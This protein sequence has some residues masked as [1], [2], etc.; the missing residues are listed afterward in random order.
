M[1]FSRGSLRTGVAAGERMIDFCPWGRDPLEVEPSLKPWIRTWAGENTIFLSP[2]DWFLRGHDLDGGAYNEK[3]YWIPRITSGTYVWSPPAA[4]AMVCLEELR[5]AR[6]KRKNSR[7]IVIIQRLMTPRW[8][9]QL[10]KAADYIFTISPC[11]SFWSTNNFEPLYVALIFPY[12][13]YRP[14]QLKQTPKFFQVGGRLSKV[15]QEN[16]ED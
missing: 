7:H 13:E 8:L 11:H 10:N 4:A 1:G 3:R 6:M 2:K 15:L 14:F 5:K 9:K 16:K 12:L